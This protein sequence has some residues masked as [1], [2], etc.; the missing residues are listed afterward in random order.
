MLV[1]P[2]ALEASLAALAAEVADALAGLHGP[3]SPAWRHERDLVIFLGGGRATLL[4]L[5]HPY[6]AYGIHHHSRTRDDVIGRFRRTFDNVFAMAFGTLDEALASARRVHRIHAHITG[7]IEEDA[8]AFP[9]G[10]PYA[11]NQPA[12][13]IWVW[14]TLVDSVVAVYAAIGEPLTAGERADYYQGATRFARLFGIAAADLPPSWD[15]F[16]AYVAATVASP[17]ITV[18][19]PARTMAGFLFGGRLGP[20]A[21]AVTAALLPPPVRAQ[22]GLPF[23]RRERALAT[24]TLTLVR[25]ARAVTPRSAWDVPAYRDAVRRLRGLPPS[26]WSRWVE[27]RLFAHAGRTALTPTSSRG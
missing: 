13:L 12:A 8:G 24:A 6:V 15:R 16:A 10:A 5:A 11:A 2:A 26:R 9:R 3:G 18:T 22:F 25:A 4:Q 1:S 23:D 27:A 17:V 14:A 21:Q 19:T 7:V 20:V